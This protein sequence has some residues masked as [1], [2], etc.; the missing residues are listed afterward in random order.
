MA[1]LESLFAGRNRTKMVENIKSGLPLKIPEAHLAVTDSVPGHVFEWAEIDGNRDMA[2]I[3]SQDSPAKRVGHQDVRMR[4]ETRLRTFEEQSYTA[5]KLRNLIDPVNG[6][7]RDQ[8]GR[9]FVTRSSLWFKKRQ[10]NLVQTSAQKLLLAFRLFFYE[11]GEFLTNSSGATVSIDVNIPA[12][13]LNPLNILGSG[14]LISGS[15]AADLAC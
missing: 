4:C 9:Q 7:V 14:D 15:W 5:N 1:S 11:S 6:G 12:G 8:M 10:L 3:V 2:L 13:P